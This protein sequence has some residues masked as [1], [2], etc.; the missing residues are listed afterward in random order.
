MDL[1]N[2][3]VPMR[4]CCG[5]GLVPMVMCCGLAVVVVLGLCSCLPTSCV[6]TIHVAAQ[7]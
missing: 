6:W 3:L 7:I 5:G 2:T 4:M 1:D